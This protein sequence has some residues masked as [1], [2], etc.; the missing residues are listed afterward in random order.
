[1]FTRA[2]SLSPLCTSSCNSTLSPQAL[3]DDVLPNGCF[4]PAGTIVAY[5]GPMYHRLKRLWGEGMCLF[6]RA[7]CALSIMFGVVTLYCSAD[8]D[9]YDPD[10]WAGARKEQIK[11]YQFLAFHGGEQR[12]LGQ[13]LAYQVLFSFPHCSFAFT[14]FSCFNNKRRLTTFAPGDESCAWGDDAKLFV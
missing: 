11:P 7:L 6:N 13:V 2:S 14:S 3:K 12:C 9:L 10:R 5:L 4:V 8:A 1:M